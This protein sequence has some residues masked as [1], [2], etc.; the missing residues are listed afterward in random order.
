MRLAL[1]LQVIFQGAP[2]RLLFRQLLE[3][4]NRGFFTFTAIGSILVRQLPAKIRSLFG[5]L[6]PVVARLP[7]PGTATTNPQP[8][9]Y[10][11]QRDAHVE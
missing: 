1:L 11:E 3:G 7:H 6:L 4:S 9:R 5:E 2:L 10:G 8:Y